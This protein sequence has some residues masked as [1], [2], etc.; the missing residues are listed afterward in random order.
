MK[1]FQHL[2]F[3]FFKKKTISKFEGLFNDQIDPRVRG[4]KQL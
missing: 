4:N 1:V 2:N 3:I